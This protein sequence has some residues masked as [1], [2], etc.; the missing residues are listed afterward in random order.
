[1]LERAGD[2]V[3]DT[4]MTGE[5][6]KRCFNYSYLYQDLKNKKKIEVPGR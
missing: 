3:A 4:D 1:M 2:G 6:R 5:E